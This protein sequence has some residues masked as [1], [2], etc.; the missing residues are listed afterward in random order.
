MIRV[1]LP[2]PL[3]SLAR[4]NREIEIWVEGPATLETVL[5]ALELQYPILRGAIRDQ[6]T[7]KRR[8]FIRFFACGQDI[9]LAS[10]A[11]PLPDALATGDEPLRIVG[12]MAGG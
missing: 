3:C 8:A 7:H 2:P 5:D 6:I 4:I 10:P 9:S 12:A 11:A 1:M